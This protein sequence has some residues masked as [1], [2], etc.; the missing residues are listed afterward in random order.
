MSG[1]D[2]RPMPRIAT[3]GPD[4]PFLEVLARGLRARLDTA[5]PLALTRAT[6]LLPTRRACRALR[7]AFLRTGG[8]GAALL[9]RILPLGDLDEDEAAAME[10]FGLGKA[11]DAASAASPLDLPQPMAAA[12]RQLLL[13]R[14]VMGREKDITPSQAV[15]LG[16]DLARLLDQVQTERLDLRRLPNLVTA[17]ELA[18]HWQ[19]IVGF[20][21]VLT[22]AWPMLLDAHGRVDPVTHRNAVMAALAEA[23]AQQA[24]DG[25]V[26][27][28]GSTGSVPATADLMGVIA[29]LPGGMVVLPGLDTAMDD[30]AWAAVEDTHPQA[31]MKRLL[32][33]LKVG[34]E[35]VVPFLEEREAPG[36]LFSSRPA[37]PS[38]ALAGRLTL[39][40][41]AMRPAATT[42]AWRALAEGRGAGDGGE[43][44]VAALA[45]GLSGLM[46]LTAPGP[47]EEASAIALMMRETLETG[48]RTC[49]LVTP[50]RTLARR[51]KAALGRWGLP[52]DDSA[53][54][55]LDQT[56][57][58]AFLRLAARAGVEGLAPVSLLALLK[59][60][61][62]SGG[63]PLDRFRDRVRRLDR[64]VLR[65]PRPDT[66]VAG[67]RA[68]VLARVD[69]AEKVEPLL[70][71]CDRLELA[72]GPFLALLNQPEAPL[73]GLLEAHMRF[74]ESLADTAEGQGVLP[75]AARLWEGDAGEAAA[76]LAID[77]A[78]A[79]PAMEMIAPHHYP[80]VLDALM[81][82]RVVR[83]NRDLHSRLF[84]WGPL[85]ARLQRADRVILGGLNEGSWPA[86]V[87]PGPWMSRPMLAEFG[88]PQP[89]RRIGL[90]AHDVSQLLCA[91]DV[92]VTRAARVDGTPTVPSRWLT[93]LEAV[94][95]A[96][97]LADVWDAAEEQ[98][99]VY[100]DWARSLETPERRILV[101]PPA[102]T[103]PVAARPR[104]LSVTRVE[105]WMRDPYALYA[106][107]IL[108][109]EPLDPLDADPSVA[110]YGTLVH[111]A[112]EAFAKAFPRDLPADPE[113]ELIALGRKAFADAPDRPGVQAFWWPRFERIAP[114]IAEMER[115]RRPLVAEVYAERRGELTV[116][117]PAGPFTLTA[118]ADRLERLRD[119]ALT[120]I[121]YKTGTLPSLT[122]VDAGYAPQLPL[123]AAMAEAGAFA[124]VPPGGV[125]ELAFWKL[126]GDLKGGESRSASK[127][128]HEAGERALR[129]FE[130]LVRA[131]D[132]EGTPYMARPHPDRAPKYNAYQHLARVAEWSSQED[133]G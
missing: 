112:L 77:L 36:D 132:A 86:A 23:W 91:P 67:L 94:V 64:I 66:G 29:R 115:L 106:E 7:E 37:V 16:D 120:V 24:P 102:P 124:G 38:P 110:D 80:A 88:L 21:S 79:A 43:G 99:A 28:A 104:S 116:E 70:D 14:L 49:A 31:G 46:R 44:T 133:E 47:R 129:G 48:G 82:G 101:P 131:F 19:E 42:D 30:D 54:Q 26:I 76:R 32:A 69:E 87:D 107:K 130:A 6:V 61:L 121:D 40:R 68:A 105:L 51:V 84:I 39:V 108:R 27:A 114:W 2:G 52:V 22:E 123:E 122:E 15:R 71:L 58:G 65:G 89:E 100:L 60:P 90:A 125:R 119:G 75:G 53:G 3:I 96:A 59:H 25:P 93:R 98:G 103:P 97:G 12:T 13:A 128:P 33:H 55:P 50:D 20:L 111:A 74:C 35:A 73:A 127:N 1:A 126:R 18:D 4:Q 8:G 81:A 78:D 56:A 92:V 83:P 118:T 72:A 63:L 85:E 113:A 95:R 9:P 17:L 34:R 11:G 117:G 41:E 45:G 5:D 62:A 10:I 109:L 57:P